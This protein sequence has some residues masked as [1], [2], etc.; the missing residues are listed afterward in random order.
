MV[1]LVYRVQLCTHMYCRVDRNGTGASGPRGGC[2][3]DFV[4]SR[5]KIIHRARAARPRGFDS[6]PSQDPNGG[7]CGS[8]TCSSAGSSKIKIRTSSRH[9]ANLVLWR[10]EVR[11][12]IFDDPAEL[13]ERKRPQ[14]R[15]AQLYGTCTKRGFTLP[16]YENMLVVPPI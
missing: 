5:K 8:Y 11:I 3:R 1:L 14:F 16:K 4:K 6:L 9:K 13:Y 12:L 7:R 15:S 10:D 2:A